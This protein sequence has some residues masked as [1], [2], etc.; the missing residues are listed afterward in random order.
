MPSKTVTVY[1]KGDRDVEVK[2]PEVTMGAILSMECTDRNLLARLKAMKIMRF[3]EGGR[4]RKVLS[5]LK[6]IEAIHGECPQAEVQNMGE[7]DIIITYEP[8]KPS[9]P[10]MHVLKAAFA[11]IVLFCGSAFSIM[12]FN[13]DVGVTTMFGQ[14]YELVTGSQSDGFTIL[15]VTYSV[16]LTAGILIFFNHVGKKRF[17]VDPTPVEVQM[18]LYENDIQ[19]TLIEN[20][21]RKGEEEDVGTAAPSGSHRS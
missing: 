19:T 13:N 1:I 9:S 2:S 5:V 20:A 11:G 16:G 15:E 10:A 17:T 21:S 14:I 8:K 18:R 6:I 7:T 3:K 12:A 4:Q